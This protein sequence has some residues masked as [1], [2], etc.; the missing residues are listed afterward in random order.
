MRTDDL[1]RA[2]SADT[3]ARK[4]VEAVLSGAV[5]L[6]AALAG[7][8]FLGEMGVRSDLARAITHP[9]VIVKHLFPVI[10]AL[11]AFWAAV[12]MARPGSEGPAAALLVLATVPVAL[13]FT[14]IFE[15]LTLP[16][17]AW[18]MALV[19]KSRA[20]CLT[21][22]VL[23][24]LPILAGSLW[25]LRRG[26]SPHPTLSG[27]LAGLLSGGTAASV[28][29]LY[30]TEDSPFFYAV[31]YMTGIL[32]VTALGALLGSRLLRW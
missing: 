28:Y 7:F 32:A 30:C 27:A 8:V 2:M 24:S 11:G 3:T 25:A 15:A 20:Q 19:G 6:I 1:I 31:W 16:R 10:L 21:Y 14:A 26:A 18:S 17:D 29:A 4:P 23:M 5:L 22:V 9:Q 12:R 13:G